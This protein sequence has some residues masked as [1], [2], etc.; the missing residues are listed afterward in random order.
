MMIVVLEM[1]KEDV[2]FVTL[3]VARPGPTNNQIW[4]KAAES[5]QPNVMT[6][7]SQL[8]ICKSIWC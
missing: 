4:T 7:L 3:C 5:D 1:R 2:L 8:F 6:T